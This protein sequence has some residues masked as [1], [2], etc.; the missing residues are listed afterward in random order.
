MRRKQQEL[1]YALHAAQSQRQ[2]ICRAFVDAEERLASVM[3]RRAGLRDI[4]DLRRDLSTAESMIQSMESAV[5]AYQQARSRAE[6]LRGEISAWRDFKAELDSVETLLRS[7]RQRE[8]EIKR[9]IHLLEELVNE[10][11]EGL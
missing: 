5:V 11:L 6:R 8:E 9:L 7:L 2:D 4:G 10:E 3:H 1:R